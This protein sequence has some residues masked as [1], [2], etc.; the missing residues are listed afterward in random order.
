[1]GT[2]CKDRLSK[3]PKKILRDIKEST[4]TFQISHDVTANHVTIGKKYG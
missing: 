3:R 2:R 1:M 4:I